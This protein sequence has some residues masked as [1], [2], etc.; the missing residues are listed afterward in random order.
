MDFRNS[1]VPFLA[2]L[3]IFGTHLQP[4]PFVCGAV[5]LYVCA[6]VC[7]ETRRHPPVF[8]LR[9]TS[10]LSLEKVLQGLGLSNEAQLAG[11]GA[12]GIFILHYLPSAE[13]ISRQHS[14]VLRLRACNTPPD[15]FRGFWGI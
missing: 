13:I 12:P 5:C 14:P 9:G 6:P 15:S 2:S 7:V 4:I 1:L 11:P 8:F 10:H 3:N